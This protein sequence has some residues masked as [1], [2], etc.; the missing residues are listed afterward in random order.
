MLSKIRK[1]NK[2]FTLIELTVVVAIIGLLM[3]IAVPKIG[4]VRKRAAITAHNVNVPS[5]S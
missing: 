3:A 1:N 4:S 5:G 2:G